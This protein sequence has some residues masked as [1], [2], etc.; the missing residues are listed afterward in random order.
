M[1]KIKKKYFNRKTLK[2][3]EKNDIE[4]IIELFQKFGKKYHII[5]TK[6]DSNIQYQTKDTKI[7][8]TYTKTILE[9]NMTSMIKQLENRGKI[10]IIIIDNLDHENEEV[11]R[12]IRQLDKIKNVKTYKIKEKDTFKALDDIIRRVWNDIQ[13]Y[14]QD[15]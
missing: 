15:K 14:L 8:Q 4:S 2:V 11:N 7:T 9:K 13:E 5:T 6:L 3:N 10:R 12:K 1:N